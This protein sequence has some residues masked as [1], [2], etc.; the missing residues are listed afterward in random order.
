M[1]EILDV[2]SHFDPEEMSRFAFDPNDPEDR[3]F[4]V[5][6]EPETGDNPDMVAQLLALYEQQHPDQ[7]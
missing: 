4:W 1:S 2:D 6:T 7:S 5:R 3:K